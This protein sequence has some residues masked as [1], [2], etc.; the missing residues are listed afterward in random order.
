MRSILAGDV[1][2]LAPASEIPVVRLLKVQ[3]S[4]TSFAGP[5][6]LRP[7]VLPP[8]NPSTNIFRMITKSLLLVPV[9]LLPVAVGI[10][11]SVYLD[12]AAV[13]GVAF[14]FFSAKAALAPE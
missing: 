3:L 13:L 7:V 4:T 12:G 5:V 14:L 8:P 1:V 9:S 10:A 11:G 6:K 2:L